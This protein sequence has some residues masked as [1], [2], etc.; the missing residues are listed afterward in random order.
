MKKRTRS[1]F[2]ANQH[3]ADTTAA[4]RCFYSTQYEFRQLNTAQLQSNQGYQRPVDPK[5]VREIIENFDP[6]YLDDII[7]SF[8]DGFYYVI[9]GQ[10]RIAAFKHMNKGLNCLVNCKIYHGLTYEQEADMFYHLDSIKKKLRYC[11]SIRAKAEAQTDP[12][13]IAINEILTK[14]G[15][16]W[17]YTG[18][19]ST[20]DNTL[21]ASKALVDNYTELGP[22]LFELTI[23]LL[24]HT[25]NG[26]RESM[27]AAFVKGIALF[28]K[29][30][31]HDAKEDVF[32]KKLSILTP[33]EV[34]SL[35]RAELNVSKV[36]V[37][38][39]RVFYNRYNYRAG[40]AKLEYRLE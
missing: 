1:Q 40:P 29:A 34:K 28:V 11:D 25:W 32:I 10:N 31:V 4:L 37:K 36:D 2:T 20:T 30:Y 38:Y 21:Q 9:D 15:I 24:A 8:R 27:T 26:H 6:L 35:A 19:G 39:A 33:A 18:T 17:S 14:Y 16:K 23:R 12:T 5:H 7:V 13:I 3:K 22:H